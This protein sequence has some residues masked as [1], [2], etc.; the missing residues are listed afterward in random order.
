MEEPLIPTVY[1][2]TIVSDKD[3][4][5]FE[6]FLDRSSLSISPACLLILDRRVS[7]HISLKCET[8][9][10]ESI[11]NIGADFS[12]R[13]KNE[14]FEV[15]VEL[16]PKVPICSC[17]IK[18]ASYNNIWIYPVPRLQEAPSPRASRELFA[19]L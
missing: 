4:K 12:H 13:E 7:T 1:Q 3:E 8:R 2:R 9:S 15:N 18:V 16:A 11:P 17:K 5:K 6:E 19:R 10:S 14:T